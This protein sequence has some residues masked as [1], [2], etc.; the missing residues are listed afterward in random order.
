MT[1]DLVIETH[2]L[3]K[4]YGSRTAVDSIDIT[5]PAGVV[6]G[7]VGPNGAGKTTT[8]AMLLG[9]VTPTSGEG[10]VL[11]HPLSEPAAY[12]RHLGALI[13][14]PA[15]YRG[16]SGAEN[17]RVLATIGGYDPAQSQSCLNWWAWKGGVET[18][19]APT[20]WE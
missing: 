12:L 3:T 10:A 8:M 18:A 15:F 20:R 17:L 1:T 9:L 13:E 6:A 16:L 11:G 7:F 5:V 14:Q 4:R 2:G 19:S